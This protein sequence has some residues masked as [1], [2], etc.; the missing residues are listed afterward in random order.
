VD[1]VGTKDCKK[2]VAGILIGIIYTFWS[3]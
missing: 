1:H 2:V 3:L